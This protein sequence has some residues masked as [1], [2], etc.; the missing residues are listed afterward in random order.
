MRLADLDPTLAEML[1]MH[2]AFGRLGFQMRD[3]YV[4]PNAQP[5]RMGVGLKTLGMRDAFVFLC[6]PSRLSQEAL[7]QAWVDVVTPLW[8]AR[9]DALIDELEARY[10]DSTVLKTCT[11]WLPQ[12]VQMGVSLPCAAERYATQGR[13][14]A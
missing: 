3:V 8:K 13:G 12:L 5:N 2:A 10:R 6:A 4:M 1:V 7:V 11:R 9:D 14:H